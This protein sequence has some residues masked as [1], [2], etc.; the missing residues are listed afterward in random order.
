M[1]DVGLGTKRDGVDK[2]SIGYEKLHAGVAARRF[3]GFRTCEESVHEEMLIDSTVTEHSVVGG[4]VA[5]KLHVL[6][7]A[8]QLCCL[9]QGT[10]GSGYIDTPHTREMF[11]R[12]PPRRTDTGGAGHGIVEVEAG[13][14]GGGEWFARIVEEVWTGVCSSRSN[15]D[16]VV[17]YV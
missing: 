7:S 4:I 17:A 12:K 16:G 1:Y 6:S 10:S 9:L 15:G 3:L 8:A 13:D 14:F 5:R 11:G 2:P